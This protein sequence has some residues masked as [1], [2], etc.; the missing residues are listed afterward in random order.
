MWKTTLAL[1]CLVFGVPLGGC[2]D[3]GKSTNIV[4]ESTY[5]L[6]TTA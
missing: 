4:C 1:S 2:D 6:C 5:A 3:D